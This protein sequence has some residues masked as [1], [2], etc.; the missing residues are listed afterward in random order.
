MTS[1]EQLEELLKECDKEKLHLCGHVQSFGAL[2][3]VR[4]EDTCIVYAS[5]NL[6]AFLHVNS[7]FAHKTKL[8][9]GVSTDNSDKVLQFF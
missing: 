9:F 2:I 3:G 7:T 1:K 6:E 8:F 4:K 5:E